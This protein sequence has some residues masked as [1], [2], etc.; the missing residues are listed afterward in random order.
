[1][2]PNMEEQDDDNWTLLTGKILTVFD[3]LFFFA[4][5]TPAAGLTVGLFALVLFSHVQPRP[6]ASQQSW[7]SKRGPCLQTSQQ[8]LFN[9]EERVGKNGCCDHCLTALDIFFSCAN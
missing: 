7:V 9:F 1:M 3:N 8:N 4:S 2:E 5:A 6:I